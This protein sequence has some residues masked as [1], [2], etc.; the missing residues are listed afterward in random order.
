[1]I[2]KNISS[3]PWVVGDWYLVDVEYDE[4][5]NPDTG[6]G[7]AN[8]NGSFSIDKLGSVSGYV[9]NWNQ[10][11]D[12]AGVGVYRG[13]QSTADIQLVKVLRTEY[14][15]QQNVL[16]AI[17]KVPNDCWRATNSALDHL[18]LELYHCTNPVKI[19]KI[20]TRNIS[21]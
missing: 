9:G 16:R 11:I 18:A 13:G 5:F 21:T 17:F 10:P 15:T 1:M 7:Y 2:E 3:D 6:A 4:T 20:I 12:P 19:Q 14:G 8:P